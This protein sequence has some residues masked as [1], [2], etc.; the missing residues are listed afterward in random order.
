MLKESQLEFDRYLR[1][2][3]K[4]AHARKNAEGRASQ[5]ENDIEVKEFKNKWSDF[6]QTQ[7][8]L[9]DFKPILGLDAYEAAPK[10]IRLYNHYDSGAVWR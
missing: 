5:I 1:L 3:D 4:K 2:H 10:P 9:D 6:L 8:D 7:E